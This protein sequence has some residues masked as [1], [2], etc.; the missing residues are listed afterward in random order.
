MDLSITQVIRWHDQSGHAVNLDPDGTLRE[1]MGHDK[2]WR[3]VA[4]R[5]SV[6]AARAY[7]VSV[8]V[9]KK[10]RSIG[11]GPLSTDGDSPSPAPHRRGQVNVVGCLPPLAD[12]SD[13]KQDRLDREEKIAQYQE[14][15]GKNRPLFERKAALPT[16][17][18]SLA[19]KGCVKVD[20]GHAQPSGPAL[21]RMRGNLREPGAN[22]GAATAPTLSPATSAGVGQSPVE[23]NHARS[24]EDSLSGPGSGRAADGDRQGPARRDGEGEG[25]GARALRSVDGEGETEVP[26]QS[27]GG[28]LM[29]I[30]LA[31]GVYE[32]ATGFK[33]IRHRDG[34][35][36][37]ELRLANNASVRLNAAAADRLEA[38]IQRRAF[39]PR[40]VREA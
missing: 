27:H 6:E 29:W 24:V 35:V 9:V 34:R 10:E 30:K 11:C 32:L 28:G 5:V 15:A 8:G 13:P 26:D 20:V 40:E 21:A 22:P 39:S 23:K 12:A 25:L 4:K 16:S 18:R 17:G 2:P 31:P 37:G 19:A 36:E 7:A 3:T 14:L 38:E 1:R 33:R